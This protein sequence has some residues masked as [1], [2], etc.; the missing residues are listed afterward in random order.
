MK[1]NQKSN[2]DILRKVVNRQPDEQTLLA[3]TG[4]CAIYGIHFLCHLSAFF[5]NFLF[6]DRPS[7]LQ[8]RKDIEHF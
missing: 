7:C 1:K 8:E 2:V 6:K 5:Y 3:S 4:F